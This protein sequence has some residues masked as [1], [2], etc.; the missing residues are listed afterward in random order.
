M[1]GS[2]DEGGTR[3]VRGEIGREASALGLGRRELDEREVVRTWAVTRA[4]Q[5]S[6]RSRSG[7]RSSEVAPTEL[8][9]TVTDRAR[10]PGT[11]TVAARI[12]SGTEAPDG[13][14]G[15][16]PRSQSGQPP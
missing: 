4:V 7:S 6:R 11:G 5:K 3:L 15:A 16:E 1:R 8:D 2:I 13:F 9:R 12:R 10:S 14:H